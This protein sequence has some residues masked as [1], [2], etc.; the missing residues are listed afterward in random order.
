MIKG[1]GL[2]INTERSRVFAEHASHDRMLIQVDAGPGRPAGRA[3]L[4]ME[5][6]R[7][8]AMFLLGGELSDRWGVQTRPGVVLDAENENHALYMA[9][10]LREAKI[11]AASA[12]HRIAGDWR[13]I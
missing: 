9:R 11:W 2:S 6:R 1:R 3:V 5:Q 10:R 4:S 12:V 13:K 8:L 7:E